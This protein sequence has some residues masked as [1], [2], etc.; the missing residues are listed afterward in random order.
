MSQNL[1]N[2]LNTHQFYID[3]RWVNPIEQNTI[4]VINPATEQ[5]IVQ[6]AT[7]GEDDVNAA[8]SAAKRAFGNFSNSSIKERIELLAAINAQLI[9]RN[10]DIATAISLEMGAPYILAKNAQA[11][12]GSQHFAEIINVL[13]KHNFS[14]KTTN[15]TLVRQEAIGVCALITPWNWPLNQIATKVAPALAAGCTMVL[16]PSEVAP[17]SAI[18]LAEIMDEVGVPK[19]V[20]N[21]IHGTGVSIGD[22]LTGHKDVDMVSFTGSTRAGVAI[23]HSCAPSIKRVSLE[24]GG[25]SAGIISGNLDIQKVARQVV[26]SSMLNSGQSCN[27]LTRLLIPRQQYS[28]I[29][30][31]I[32][33]AV[34]E[35]IVDL[36]SL[37]PDLGP[38]ANKVQFNKIKK[39]IEQGVSQGATLLCGG[40]EMPS[41]VNKGYFIQPT[42]FG[43]V[44]TDMNIAQEEVFGPVL[45]LMPYDTLSEAITIANDSE[46]GLSGYVW[47]DNHQKAVDIANQIRTG[48][49]HIN[50]K[51]LDSSAPFGGFKMSGNGREWGSYGLDEFIEYKSIYGGAL[52]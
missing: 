15:G 34:N 14:E 36:P 3:G 21:L 52:K 19:G 10:D 44:T 27:A 7:A 46:Y 30:C 40:S 32:V 25:K 48:M 35:L 5:S 23:S 39:L 20:F 49:V 2:N 13:R 1:I 47:H 37:N 12:S 41:N 4:E 24:L 31:A 9:L 18:I 50:G 22:S 29:S 33:D 42:V 11:P 38:V 8:V 16:K 28:E 45:S 43:D 26:S 6:L 17:L 51:G